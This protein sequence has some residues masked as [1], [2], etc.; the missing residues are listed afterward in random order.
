MTSTSHCRH[1][2][3]C[4]VKQCRINDAPVSKMARVSKCLSRKF[5]PHDFM[6]GITTAGSSL[7]RTLLSDFSL[8]L[9]ALVQ[10]CMLGTVC[11]LTSV[12][13][14]CRCRPACFCAPL[15]WLL[16]TTLLQPVFVRELCRRL[17]T[18]HSHR[19]AWG[20]A[21]SD[22]PRSL[23]LRGQ[24][25]VR[26]ASLSARSPPAAGPLWCRVVP[27]VWRLFWERL[28][29][30]GSPVLGAMVRLEAVDLRVG[31]AASA[32]DSPVPAGPNESR[33]PDPPTDGEVQLLTDRPTDGRR[34]V[35][36]LG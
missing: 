35:P 8:R 16:C 13:S 9:Y 17:P 6:I 27:G 33:Q 36:S 19:P 18:Q 20:R 30:T 29:R 2:L 7:Q 11:P 3:S 34:A 28:R 23:L 14:T 1:R 4:G 5:T 12:S 10:C 24:P 31:R 32:D 15:S 22:R 26:G 25:S 21:V